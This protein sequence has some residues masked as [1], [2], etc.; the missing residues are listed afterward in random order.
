MFPHHN[1]LR[2]LVIRLAIAALVAFSC[3]AFG[4]AGP[5]GGHVGGG[6]AGAGGL[7]GPGIGGA[8]AGVDVKDELKGFHALIAVQAR[9]DQILA[10]AAM[11]NTTEATT[12]QLRA[13]LDH[14]SKQ[15]TASEAAPGNTALNEAIERARAANKK[16]LD[17][18][19]EQQKSGL[20]EVI[21]KLLKEDSDLE[22][23][24]RAL[25]AAANDARASAQ[26]IAS[27]TQNLDHA[28]AAFRAGQA[29]LGEEMSIATANH[30]ASIF[31]L[32]PAKNTI[33]FG[34]QP[35][36]I[37]TSGAI[38][39]SKAA[40]EKNLFNLELTSDLSDLQDNISAVLRMQL[41][42]AHRCGERVEIQRATLTPLAPACGVTLQL[43]FERWLCRGGYT[44][45]VAEGNGGFEVKLTPSIAEDGTLRLTPQTG[46][47]DAQ[48]VLADA[49]RS[50]SLGDDLRGKVA[51][52]VL[53][54]IRRGADYKTVLPPAAQAHAR[55]IHAQFE[56]TGMGRLTVVLSGE[57]SLSKDEAAQLTTELKA[58]AVGGR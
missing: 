16:F 36:T 6:N 1:L 58:T 56:G 30:D 9:K 40:E 39:R 54:V 57:V 25:S 52:S 22:Q 38:S 11:M 37:T 46:T 44:S 14:V 34:R 33:A 4:Q 42:Q 35:V 15:T 17:S 5:G 29:D 24:A 51:E 2:S 32:A 3:L 45:E 47:I 10:Y 18:F 20:K 23:Q 8:S 55:L 43:H 13:F 19:S 7:S 31:N 27:T 21:R 50:G 49:L 12:A 28:L 26:Q 53:A 41:D 48:G